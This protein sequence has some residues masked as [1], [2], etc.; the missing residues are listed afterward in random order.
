MWLG[1]VCLYIFI[2]WEKI[3]HPPNRW[4][5]FC[6]NLLSKRE[7]SFGI[8]IYDN[9]CSVEREWKKKRNKNVMR[10]TALAH[11][12]SLPLFV[13][14]EFFFWL[15]LLLLLSAWFL[16]VECVI[17]IYYCLLILYTFIFFLQF[18]F[19]R[20]RFWLRHSTENN[21]E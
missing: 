10:F 3:T 11:C 1:C 2:L 8:T 18:V 6:G 4:F 17:F 14:C 9:V 20:L 13:L 12:L 7:D 16:C 15:S 5:S 19:F 21:N